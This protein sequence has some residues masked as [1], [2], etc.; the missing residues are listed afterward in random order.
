[1]VSSEFHRDEFAPRRAS[2][3]IGVTGLAVTR[4]NLAHHGHAVGVHNRSPQRTRALVC[5]HGHEASSCLP[6]H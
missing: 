2:A 5:E 4:H 6:S 1:M 3:D